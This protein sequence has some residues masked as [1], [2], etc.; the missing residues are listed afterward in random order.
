MP[1]SKPSEI[2]ALIRLEL[3]KAFLHLGARLDLLSIVGRW[4]DTIMEDEWV[5]EAL[6][7]WNANVS[8]FRERP[9]D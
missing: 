8:S 2:E 4:G 5:L 1:V 6:K 7:D 9:T 3:V